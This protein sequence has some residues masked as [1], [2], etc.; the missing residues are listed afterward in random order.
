MDLP[1]SSSRR[2]F[3]LNVAS[4]CSVLLPIT[5][6]AQAA[7]LVSERDP[8]AVALGYVSDSARVDTRKYPKFAVG[9]GCCNCA[10][11][12]G[13]AAD[14][15]GACPLFAG[16]QVARSGWCSAFASKG[17]TGVC[18][19]GSADPSPLPE[20][21]M[22]RMFTSVGVLDVS[23][24]DKDAPLSV[25]NFLRYVRARSYDGT[26]IHRAM[27][28]FVIQGGGYNVQN[29]T[30]TAIPRSRPVAL[31]YS[32]S[33]PN[34]LGTFAMARADGPNSATSE[35]FVNTADNTTA[36]GEGNNGGYAVFGRVTEP[37][38]SVVAA[39]AALPVTSVGA[40]DTLPVLSARTGGAQAADLVYVESVVEL[41][42]PLTQADRALSFLEAT[43]WRYLKP[44]GSVSATGTA[45][46]TTYYF[47]YYPRSDAYVGVSVPGNEVFY[48]VPEAGPG[49]NRLST[50]AE[51]MPTVIGA[52]Y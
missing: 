17:T 16:K 30:L 26:I 52:G 2:S 44:P 6:R 9:Q 12:Q 19:A 8:Q 49:I 24:L 18:S 15:A 45:D 41:P 10:L 28:D 46:G 27:K 21:T 35:W 7:S 40:F 51:L 3:V 23:L 39:V 20:N 33:R 36:L 29:G 38:L 47:R 37:G 34:A 5:A 1:A 11:F 13:G 42:K 43:Y 31:E 25:Q 32:N 22:V 50:L 48:L 14:S 4:S